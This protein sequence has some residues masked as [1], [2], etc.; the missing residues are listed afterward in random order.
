MISD[1][2][3]MR[4]NPP[5]DNELKLERIY[6]GVDLGDVLE[7]IGWELHATDGAR[8]TERS[9]I[10]AMDPPTYEELKILRYVVDPERIYLGRKSKRELAKEAG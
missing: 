7:N 5:Q 9:R 3:I 6:P 10:P 1:L 2:C 4:N 8:V